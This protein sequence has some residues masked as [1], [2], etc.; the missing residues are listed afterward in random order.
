MVKTHKERKEKLA[1]FFDNIV[2]WYIFWAIA[3]LISYMVS[4]LIIRFLSFL[5]RSFITE[6]DWKSLTT[7]QI[8][9]ELLHN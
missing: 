9:H 3:W 1:R 5:T 2:D 4:T 6:D 8:Q 7:T